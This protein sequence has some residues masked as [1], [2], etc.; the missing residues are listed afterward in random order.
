MRKFV[1]VFLVGVLIISSFSF[2]FATG[3]EKIDN[4]KNV[5][6]ETLTEEEI[7]VMG[8]RVPKTFLDLSRNDYYGHIE[9]FKVCIYTEVGFTNTNSMDITLSG[10]D[11][12]YFD[13]YVKKGVTITL[14]E[15]TK[16]SNKKIKSKT[17]SKR[18]SLNMSVSNLS[19]DKKYF[20]AVTKAS[21]GVYLEDLD[22][23]VTE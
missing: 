4:P 21:D 23:K 15:K 11:R 2:V 10:I 5:Y 8:T 1:S 6:R 7:S 16:Y 18:T 12:S 22:L 9:R 17:T 19:K 13:D 14:Y 3:N 20:V